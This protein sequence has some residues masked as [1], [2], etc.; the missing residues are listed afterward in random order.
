MH[1]RDLRRLNKCCVLLCTF[2]PLTSVISRLNVGCLVVAY[3]FSAFGCMQGPSTVCYV[4]CVR[5]QALTSS[6]MDACLL[7]GVR[8][9]WMHAETFGVL[10]I[11]SQ[12]FISA[13]V[14]VCCLLHAACRFSAW[15]YMQ[16]RSRV[17]YMLGIRSKTSISH[18]LCC[19]SVSA[20]GCVQRPSR[21]CSKRQVRRRPGCSR[22]W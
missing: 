7:R 4:L 9:L 17:C 15:G 11:R 3:R 21:V 14:N 8:L 16:G 22:R 2:C 19:M 20:C 6:R 1:T 13:R 5:S 10:C 18:G 12:A